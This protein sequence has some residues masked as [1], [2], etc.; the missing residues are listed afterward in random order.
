M[1][2]NYHYISRRIFLLL[3]GFVFLSIS[4]PF[5]SNAYT[6]DVN[7]KGYNNAEVYLGLYYGESH[8]VVDSAFTNSNGY[9]QFYSKASLQQGVYFVAIPPYSRFELL[10]LEDQNFSVYTDI[11]K[12][13]G[14]LTL[15]N[16]DD[17]DLFISM[18]LEIASLNI[19]QS[20]LDMKKQF[21]EH[22]GLSDSVKNVK[23][24]LDLLSDARNEIYAK[25]LDLDM[26]GF[27]SKMIE[28]ILP[29]VFSENVLQLKYNNPNAYYN[30]YKMHFFDRVDFSDSRILYTPDF[31]FH[32]L[33]N[34]YCTFFLDANVNNRD[35]V[36]NDVDVLISQSSINQEVNQ[37]VISFLTANYAT[38]SVQ[39]MDAVFVYLADNYYKQGKVPWVDSTVIHAVLSE[40]DLLRYNL[41]GN[42][43]IDIQLSDTTDATLSLHQIDSKYTILWFWEPDCVSC[44]QQTPILQ[45]NY[46][47][48]KKYGV[49]VVAVYTGT[50]KD[51][52]IDYLR[53]T[54][55]Q[56]I[57]LYDPQQNSFM[58]K[59]YGTSK[60][61]RL[62]ILNREK[63]ILAKDISPE[64]LVPYLKYFEK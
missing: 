52:W 16:Y 30:Y 54:N 26:D 18:Q 58:Y 5:V 46:A 55:T 31:V 40:A 61:P 22:S 37:Y 56:W 8:F 2:N 3:A 62:F 19:K 15:T 7:I 39:G 45:E 59:Y 44:E 21:F 49:E 10:I 13:L 32:R 63:I 38:P 1:V 24:S 64:Y 43:A 29:P 57:N 50:D 23:K 9:A 36:C 20:Q 17:S 34:E 60:T 33:L 48:L 41:V 14:N 12:I 11:Q 4:F 6:I 25:Y 27:L 51:L 53:E 35:T 28:M 47:Q 42:S